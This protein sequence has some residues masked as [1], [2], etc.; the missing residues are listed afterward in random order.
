MMTVTIQIPGKAWRAVTIFADSP[1]EIEHDDVREVV[2]NAVVSRRGFGESVSVKGSRDAL[3]YIAWIF[4]I[5]GTNWIQ[6]DSIEARQDGR[7]CIRAAERIRDALSAAG[8]LRGG[9]PTDPFYNRWDFLAFLDFRTAGTVTE[10]EELAE[11]NNENRDRS[12]GWRIR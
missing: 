7:A 2:E 10:L 4:W 3:V 9:W 11:R 6:N 1:R 12:D 5:D 8:H